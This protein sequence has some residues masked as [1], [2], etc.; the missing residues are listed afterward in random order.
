MAKGQE[1][2]EL[3][4]S[5]ATSFLGITSPTSLMVSL[6]AQHRQTEREKITEAVTSWWMPKI[7]KGH[8]R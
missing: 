4:S 6:A 2:S 1:A 8:R 7:E 3:D 5:H